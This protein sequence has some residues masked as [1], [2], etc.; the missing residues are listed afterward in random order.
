MPGFKRAFACAAATLAATV[1][2]GLLPSSGPLVSEAEAAG[3]TFRL[4]GRG[5]GHNVGM[6]QW[7]A[8]GLAEKGLS[9]SQIIKYYYAGVGVQKKTLPS[10]I[11]VGLLQERAE[12][13]IEGSG[14]F[15]FLDATG[16][17][18][19]TGKDGRWRIVPSGSKLD[20]YAPGQSSAKFSSSAPLFVRFEERGTLLDLP[21]TGHSYKHGRLEVDANPST[22]KVRAVLT[23][24]F[25]EYLYGLGEMPSSWHREALEAQAIAGR[26]YAFEKIERLG[27]N[28][29]VCNCA[30]YSTTADQAYVGVSHEVSRWVAAV[31]TTR[32]Y[33]ATYKGEP[34]QALYSSSSGGYTENNENV[35]GGKPIPYLRGRC[36]VGDYFGGENPHSN[37]TVVMDG[38]QLGDKMSKAG[39]D[40]GQV[41]SLS[42]PSPRGVSGLLGPVKDGKGGVV[43]TG[44]LDTE[45]MSGG[46]FR[47]IVGLKSRLVHWHIYGGIRERWDALKCGPGLPKWKE[48][49]WRYLDGSKGG[50]SQ[51]FQRGRLFFNPSMKKVFW[52]KGPVLSDYDAR[53]KGGQEVGMP[54]LDEVGVPGGRGARFESGNIYWS[55][56][57]GAHLVQG[58]IL[59]KYKATGG[60]RKWGLPTT[61]E[62]KAAEGRTSRFVKARIYWTSKHGAHPVYGGILAEYIKRGGGTGKLG[63]PTSDEYAIKGGRKQDFQRGYITW[64]AKTK[65]TSYKL[66]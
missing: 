8:R 30:V 40:T 4:Y 24:P 16:K 60:P 47:W 22:G 7:G 45:H 2:M 54:T 9:A 56:S 58:D 6:S 51:N 65:K 21:Q 63:L 27:Q 33:V 50:R 18:K 14:Y 55:R 20:V 1:L 17:K 37:W 26:T 46:T 48:V 39:R 23:L 34:I 35:F 59:T 5:W 11:R 66:T 42:Y 38:D 61:D 15:D 36:D 41:R 52:I 28:R 53:R 64:N 19:A 31:D 43:V 32:A 57:T 49:S 3:R 13:W 10:N 12:I 25:E 44:T 62:R 29:N